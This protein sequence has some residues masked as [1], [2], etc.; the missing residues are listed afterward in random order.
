VWRDRG[1]KYFR[2]TA[3]T[4][5]IP[6]NGY[7]INYGGSSED[8]NNNYAYTTAV[9]HESNREPTRNNSHRGPSDKCSADVNRLCHSDW[10]M[11]FDIVY[12]KRGRSKRPYECLELYTVDRRVR[13]YFQRSR[14]HS[15]DRIKYYFESYV[16]RKHNFRL[17]QIISFI[18]LFLRSTK[19]A[20]TKTN[21]H[22]VL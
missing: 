4:E 5:R 21:Y 1:A 15:V 11:S 22:T 19:Y 10:S 12:K 6:A 3:N 18:W 7:F 14:I 8:R 20:T 16:E 2:S 13:Y 17:N 9:R